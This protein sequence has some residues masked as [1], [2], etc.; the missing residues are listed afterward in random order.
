MS[1]IQIIDFTL[2]QN[3]F[4][5][6]C[7]SIF[8]MLIIIS[9]EFW[10][11]IRHSLTIKIRIFYVLSLIFDILKYCI[12][13]HIIICLIFGI[14]YN[15]IITVLF[16]SIVIIKTIL[17]IP[18]LSIIILIRIYYQSINCNAY[19]TTILFIAKR[20]FSTKYYR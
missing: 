14:K 11:V 15:S 3:L 12:Q 2:N 19:Y 16:G 13:I 4:I 7:I 17:F 6:S 1:I 18:I 8:A 10:S 9:I 20:N 5:P